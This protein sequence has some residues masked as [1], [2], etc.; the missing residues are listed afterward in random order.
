VSRGR[1][2]LGVEVAGDERG[3][4]EAFG[5]RGTS[6]GEAPRTAGQTVRP[7]STSSGDGERARRE[8]ASS[9][10]ER[11]KGARPDL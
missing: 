6:Y 5:Q 9:G 8:R 10:R 1:G 11:E 3:S 2:G 4:G 7:A